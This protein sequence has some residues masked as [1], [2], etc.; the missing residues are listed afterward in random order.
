MKRTIKEETKEQLVGCVTQYDH[1][2]R[3]AEVKLCGTLCAG[4]KIHVKNHRSDWYQPVESMYVADKP[5]AKARAGQLIWLGVI[6]RAYKDDK[7]FVV[8]EIESLPPTGPSPTSP[9]DIPNGPPT[10]TPHTQTDIHELGPGAS[11]KKLKL[12]K[13]GKRNDD[14]DDDDDEGPDLPNPFR[15]DSDEKRKKGG[16]GG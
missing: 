4:N 2:R 10:D 14:D 16:E 13:H 6:N 3:R 1:A 9:I 12:S 7:V 15:I 11:S 8:L 5:K